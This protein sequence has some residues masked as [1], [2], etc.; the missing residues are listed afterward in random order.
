[1]KKVILLALVSLLIFGL[2]AAVMAQDAVDRQYFYF[3][4]IS[5]SVR[6]IEVTAPQQANSLIITTEDFD[7]QNWYDY[8]MAFEVQSTH[9]YQVV[10][11][12]QA[13]SWVTNTNNWSTHVKMNA[14]NAAVGSATD[15]SALFDVRM[16]DREGTWYPFQNHLWQAG[17]PKGGKGFWSETQENTYPS[18]IND[19]A[20]I[21]NSVFHDVTLRIVNADDQF[22]TGTLGMRR[23]EELLPG[24]YAGRIAVHVFLP[25]SMP[26]VQ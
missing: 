25:L 21:N 3:T 26:P 22:T 23:I 14:N 18:S 17:M 10:L 12:A 7:L 11:Y 9:S 2:S 15:F 24:D 13:A 20:S 19:T 5:P 1:M 6:W 4:V 16:T 8:D